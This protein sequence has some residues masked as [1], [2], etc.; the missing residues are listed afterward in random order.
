MAGPKPKPGKRSMKSPAERSQKK[1]EPRW[2]GID[3][4]VRE[5]YEKRVAELEA[6]RADPKAQAELAAALE[7]IRNSPPPWERDDWVP[8][9]QNDRP[10]PGFMQKRREAL[11]KLPPLYTTIDV[12]VQ[13]ATQ[14]PPQAMTLTKLKAARKKAQDLAT[15]VRSDAFDDWISTYVVTAE[16]PD[17]WTQA[18]TLYE[19][20]LKRAKDYGWNRPDKRVAKEELATETQWGRMMGSLFTKK[21]RRNGWYYPLR[22]KQGA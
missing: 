10:P 16:R 22:L 12:S 14:K 19:N 18:R 15:T 8:P 21:R 13:Q 1:V 11:A 17:E 3:P 9:D 6:W 20:Y 5:A 4:A 7:R 2:D